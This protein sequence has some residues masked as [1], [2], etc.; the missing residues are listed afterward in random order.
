MELKQPQVTAAAKPR[1]R[2]G[3]L[4]TCFPLSLLYSSIKLLFKAVL[5]ASASP[6]DLMCSISP[7]YF[8]RVAHFLNVVWLI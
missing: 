5:T 7:Y 4:S 6:Q 1:G 3:L 8:F 2:A